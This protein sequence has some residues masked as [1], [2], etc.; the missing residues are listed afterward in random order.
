MLSIACKSGIVMKRQHNTTGDTDMYKT[1]TKSSIVLAAGLLVLIAFVLAGS[2]CQVQ[3]R[4]VK[5]DI[6]IEPARTEYP[7]SGM[8]AEQDIQSP[9]PYP[10]H[11]LPTLAY[12]D[13]REVTAEPTTTSPPVPTPLPKPVHTPIPTAQPPF[14]AIQPI[15][16]RPTYLVAQ[17]DSVSLQIIESTD[18]EQLSTATTGDAG[19]L[20]PESGDRWGDI[21]PDGN[22]LVLSF[23]QVGP[24]R[25]SMIEE[26]LQ[27]LD[28]NTGI[29]E[30]IAD[31]GYDPHWSPD[32]RWIV[33]RPAGGKLDAYS[34]ETGSRF[35]VCS[36]LSLSSNL[37]GTEWS[38]DGNQLAIFYEITP[39]TSGI[40][41][42]SLEAPDDCLDSVPPEEFI[43]SSSPRWSPDGRQHVY[44]SGNAIPSP[45]GF[46]YNDLWVVNADGTGARRLT[47]QMVV[48][49][50]GWSPDSR[51]IA[52]SGIELFEESQSHY[53]LWITGLLGN[54]LIRLTQ[55]EDHYLVCWSNDGSSLFYV[56]GS[57]Q[58]MKLS[59]I[60]GEKKTVLSGID[61][62][63]ICQ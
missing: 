61:E 4:V 6:Q 5:P 49:S 62:L 54:P 48:N 34:L 51:W 22:K 33:Y 8:A 2:A 15:P 60:S 17:R 19:K 56:D 58:L 10:S 39:S 37:L 27:I 12:R 9:Y 24:S 11:P 21:S 44:F 13:N 1:N 52:F 45:E 25:R 28:L 50:A 23:G 26:S 47:Q 53:D 20:R 14:V 38:P 30:K 3:K 43:W 16:D 35:P 63:L 46:Y 29:W 36:T 55:N 18:I 40:A 41:R 7:P 57:S 32:G 42:V 59:L 31:R